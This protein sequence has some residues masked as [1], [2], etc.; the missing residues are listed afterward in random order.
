MI[1]HYTRTNSV[2]LTFDLPRLRSNEYSR[3]FD[4]V[5]NR[6]NKMPRWKGVLD[7]IQI[8]QPWAY[9]RADISR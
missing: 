9:I 4:S 8:E 5:Q 1:L 2:G 6:K 3:F 7:E